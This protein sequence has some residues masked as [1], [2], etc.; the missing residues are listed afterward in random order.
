MEESDKEVLA[1]PHTTSSIMSVLEK[2]NCI[3]SQRLHLVLI[4]LKF[5]EILN[6]NL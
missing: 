3:K 5:T 4:V 1:Y 6:Q 2:I